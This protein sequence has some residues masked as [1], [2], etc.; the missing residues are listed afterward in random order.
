MSGGAFDYKQY[1]LHDIRMKLDEEA[2]TA[3]PHPVIQ[4]HIRAAQHA[5]VVAEVYAQRLDWLLAGDDAEHSFL[6]RL[7]EDLQRV[8]RDVPAPG[9][10]PSAAAGQFCDLPENLVVTRQAQSADACVVEGT[11]DGYPFVVSIT[12]TSVRARSVSSKMSCPSG[13]RTRAWLDV[14]V[15]ET[16]KG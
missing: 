9:P 12:P 14:G 6:T 16:T 15:M 3:N 2:K 11:L 4:H 5:L 7:E 1:V 10:A 8:Q 13:D